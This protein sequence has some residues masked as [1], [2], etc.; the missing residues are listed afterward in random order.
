MTTL[1]LY[2]VNV[3]IWGS[4]WFMIT[5]QLGTVDPA[6]SVLYRFSLSFILMWLF[7]R[8]RRLRL[9]FPFK[10]HLF[11][12]LQGLLMFS[13]G[14]WLVYLAERHL[15]SGLAAVVSSSIIVLNIINA[16]IFLKQKIRL[17][18]FA[19]ALLGLAGLALIFRPELTNVTAT[20]QVI[21]SLLY[22]VVSTCL[23]SLGNITAARNI[24][25]GLPVLQ[26]NAYSMGYGALFMLIL[27]A[28]LRRPFAFPLTISYIGS[29]LYLCILGSLVAFWCYVT[30]IGRI[31]ADGAAYGPVAV[32]VIALTLSTLFE[33]YRWTPA[34]GIG[35]I[36]ILAGN[37]IV[38][39][40][41]QKS[42]AAET[43][44]EMS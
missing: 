23:F 8:A 33:S 14:Y 22:S 42:K 24:Q 7:C 3:L 16:W 20:S 13:V 28:V 37:W 25:K 34:A 15:T 4:T 38:L 31:G 9:R 1:F 5:F 36:L 19:G 11:M 35:L 32:P 21:L 26:N 29:L 10:A 30:L 41:K 12:A 44:P 43:H 27:I 17:T 39:Q 40:Q 18:V 2:I 6:V